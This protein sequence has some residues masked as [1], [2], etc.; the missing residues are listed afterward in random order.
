MTVRRSRSEAGARDSSP[1]SSPP[2]TD[3]LPPTSAAPAK[4]SIGAPVPAA[5]APVSE[6]TAA[7]AEAS[8]NPVRPHESCW[9]R[10][11][12]IAGERSSTFTDPAFTDQILATAS[13]RIAH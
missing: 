4:P 9:Q 10:R 5:G 13:R 3:R 2:V 7:D 12:E 11:A 1:D 6:D 8:W